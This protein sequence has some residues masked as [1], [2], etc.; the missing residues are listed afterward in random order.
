[1]FLEKEKGGFINR[2]LSVQE[3]DEVKFGKLNVKQMI[4]HCEDRFRML[5]GEI[6]GLYKQNVDMQEIRAKVQRGESVQTVDGLD[7]VAGEGT[8]PT[9]FE[10]DK[11]ILVDYINRFSECNNDFEFSF[12]PFMGDINGE[13]WE[14][15]VIHHLDHHLGQFGR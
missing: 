11:Q 9:V 3:N 15:V 2:V 6:E 4:C 10:Q 7:Q 14:K 1:M 13:Y 5:F 12:H 8:Q